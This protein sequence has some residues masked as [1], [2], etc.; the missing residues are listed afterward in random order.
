MLI[1]NHCTTVR[2]TNHILEE[3]RTFA[4]NANRHPSA[5]IRDALVQYLRANRREAGFQP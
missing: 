4:K 5:V 3:L 2:I 1:Y